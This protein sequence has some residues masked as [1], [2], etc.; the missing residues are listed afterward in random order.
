MTLQRILITLCILGTT[1]CF[2]G[3]TCEFQV[4]AF[5]TAKNDQ[6][7]ISFVLE[8]QAWFTRMSIKNNFCF[9][10]TDD[11]EQLNEGFLFDDAVVIFRDSRPEKTH[12]REAFENYMRQGGGWMGFHF[13]GFAL[14]TSDVPQN[15]EWYHKNFLGSGSYKSN[16]WSPTSAVLRSENI[17]HPILKGVS[18]TF[19]SAPNEW[20]RWENDLRLNP[21]I[22]ILLSI[23]QSSFPLGTGPKPE[24][25][26][27]SGYYPVV[28]VNTGYRMVYFNMG[29]NDIDYESDTNRSLS[30]SFQS[31]N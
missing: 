6:A 12:Q 8:A 25:I 14:T 24:E 4:V 5:Y 29:H 15:W 30:S 28:W 21:Q 17:N 1:S 10:A 13:A 27:S 26:W 7:H 23:H 20:Y 2:A 31:R 11:W 16:T 22:Q 18:K 9:Q 3:K 19:R